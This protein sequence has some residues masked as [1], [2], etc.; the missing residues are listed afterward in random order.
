MENLVS[1]DNFWM[2]NS[3]L[4]IEW[5]TK[6]VENLAIVENFWVTKDS[7]N[8][9]LYCILIQNMELVYR[10]RRLEAKITK[11]IYNCM[12]TTTLGNFSHNFVQ[13]YSS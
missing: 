13:I 3:L 5:A 9:R 1:V 6:I 8:T 2:T 4:G 10:L 7:T 12:L 11:P